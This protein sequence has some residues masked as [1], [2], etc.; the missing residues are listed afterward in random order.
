[1]GTF[2][3]SAKNIILR[4]S[5]R[6]GSITVLINSSSIRRSWSFRASEWPE[7]RSCKQRFNSDLRNYLVPGRIR[8]QYVLYYSSITPHSSWAHDRH[9]NNS[10][11]T[12]RYSSCV[13]APTRPALSQELGTAS[14]AD[15]ALDV[16][17]IVRICRR[18][19]RTA[20]AAVSLSLI[21]PCYE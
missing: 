7:A 21:L 12:Q 16:G 18:A 1:M 10:S 4:D 20:A 15:D 13:Q 9:E 17:A 8:T 3:K 11:T 2:H 5:K 19:P 6:S 14:G